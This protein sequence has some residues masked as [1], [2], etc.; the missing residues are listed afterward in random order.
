MT[1][2]SRPTD[3][4][5]LAGLLA[6]VLGVALGIAAC[7]PPAGTRTASASAVPTASARRSFVRPTPTPQPT[8]LTYVVRSGDSLTTIARAW[9]TTPRSIAY[10]NRATYP[11]LDPDGAGYSPNR[12]G[13]GWRLTI[14]PGVVVDESELPTPS[15]P[16]PAATSSASAVPTD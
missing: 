16:D 10:W 11:S 1:G 7:L 8:A 15:P 13:V 14:I 2:R 6:T 12:I 9:R 4:A 5:A 3:P